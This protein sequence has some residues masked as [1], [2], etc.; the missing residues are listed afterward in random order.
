ML[1]ISFLD[2]HV[3]VGG[4]AADAI[5]SAECALDNTVAGP[6]V[7]PT[8][9]GRWWTLATIPA[10]GTTPAIPHLDF[11]ATDGGPVPSEWAAAAV[12]EPVHSYADA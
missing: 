7:P 9:T 12:P 2:S 6:A 4:T 1:T 11:T 3:H 10:G 5:P 8:L